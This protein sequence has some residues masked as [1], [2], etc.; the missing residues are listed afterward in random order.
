[1]ATEDR[2]LDRQIQAQKDQGTF[3]AATD[4]NAD[5]TYLEQQ[6]EREDLIKWQ[7]D[8][9]SEL[10]NLEHDLKREVEDDK[11]GWT[12][13]TEPA[14]DEETGEYLVQKDEKGVEQ[15]LMV[16]VKPACNQFCIQMIRTNCRPLM[17]R[18]MIMSNFQ[19]ERILQ[20]LRRTMASLIRNVCLKYDYYEIDFHDISYITT[21]V[22]NYM[23]PAPFRAMNDGE[24]RHNREVIRRVE[25]FGDSLVKSKKKGIFGF[26]G[27]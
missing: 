8:L 12:N 19:E 17:S 3:M 24:R 27:S 23:M 1:M 2:L 25:T 18:N 4:P 15:M 21:T 26:M 22:K 7:Q 14:V 13:M 5:M 16:P 6:K 11:G 9:K 10:D 20:M